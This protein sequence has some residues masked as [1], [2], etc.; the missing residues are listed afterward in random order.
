[1]DTFLGVSHMALAG[2]HPTLGFM[3]IHTNT[4]VL[5]KS[6]FFERMLKR[7]AKFLPA[8]ALPSAED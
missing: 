8:A 5:V 1:M 2:D 4:L 6:L 3:T 7:S